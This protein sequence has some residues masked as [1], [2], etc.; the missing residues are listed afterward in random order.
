MAKKVSTLDNVALITRKPS[1]AELLK[2]LA[3]KDLFI[4][5]QA[6]AQ[7]TLD[8]DDGIDQFSR[9]EQAAIRDALATGDFSALNEK[10]IAWIETQVAK[11]ERKVRSEARAEQQEIEAKLAAEASAREASLEQAKQEKLALIAQAEKKQRILYLSLAL[12]G[13]GGIYLAYRFGGKK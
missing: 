1:G 6:I 12:L 13:T 9:T 8:V 11:E 7:K 2:R 3:P 10:H 4:V 5:S